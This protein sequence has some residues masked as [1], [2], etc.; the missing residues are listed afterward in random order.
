MNKTKG[1]IKPLLTRWLRGE[2]GWKEESRL[3]NLSREDEFLSDAMEGYRRFPEAD[4]TG[5]LDRLRARLAPEKRRPMVLF[6]RVAAAVALLAVAGSAFWVLNRPEDTGLAQEMAKSAQEPAKPDEQRTLLTP[7]ADSA[8]EEADKPEPARTEAPERMAANAERAPEKEKTVEKKP[9]PAEQPP[10]LI[11]APRRNA[12]QAADEESEPSVLSDAALTEALPN[13][14]KTEKPGAARSRETAEHLSPPPPPPAPSRKEI[15]KA[16][17]QPAANASAGA[18]AGRLVEGTVTSGDGLPLIGATVVAKGTNQGAVTD[19][20]GKFSLITDSPDQ[21]LV[22]SYTGYASKE[23]DAAGPGP[24]NVKLDET[25]ALDEVQVSGFSQTKKRD[26]ADPTAEP[27]GGYARLE[28]YLRRNVKLPDEVRKDTIAGRVVLKF[29][30]EPNGKLSN[31]QVLRSLCPTCDQE[32]IRVLREGPPWEVLGDQKP[33]E[34][35]QAVPFKK[36]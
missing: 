35:I 4:H 21:K 31:F 30:V 19:L 29:I 14:K 32:A 17:S 5:S 22:I 34:V 36:E 8:A 24:L 12:D 3:E 11:A 2:T 18:P 20:D 7:A 10:G 1:H 13:A 25:L 33:V 15:S 27:R 23:L 28:R 9:A 16:E 26:S 6:Y